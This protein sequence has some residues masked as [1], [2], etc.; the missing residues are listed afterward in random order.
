MLN[1]LLITLREGL[2]AAL[3]IG[4]ILGYL[5]KI[6]QKQFYKYIFIG[7]GL[8]VASSIL[9]AILFERIA[10]GFEGRAEEIFEG[11]VMLVA[12]V[13]LT[14]MIFWM[15]KQS[16]TI[17]VDVREKVEIAV[18]KRQ[19]LGLIALAFVSIFREGIE[20]VLFMN[21][22]VVNSSAES[23]LLGGILGLAIALII[24]WIVF[25]TAVNIN[26]KRFFQITGLF[27]IFISA[28]MLAGGIHELQEAGI[29]PVFI[30]HVWDIN[31]ILDEEGILG[32]FL[33][34]MFGYNAN[35]SIA[36]VIAYL[37]YIVIALKLFF[38]TKKSK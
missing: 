12:V 30:E 16:N 24:A 22:T 34:A 26:L 11:I 18:G 2:E 6:N 35:P 25:R 15:N 32:S 9:T 19:S 38:A 23:S 27:I 21:A 37:A 33:K 13:I 20:I 1:S 7:I 10:G 29:L 5:S 3:I 28:G 36:E 8:G 17:G 31:G 14:T 4:I